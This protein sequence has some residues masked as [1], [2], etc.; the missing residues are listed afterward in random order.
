MPL[1]TV[2]LPRGAP[3]FARGPVSI[4]PA[5]TFILG[6]AATPIWS[7]EPLPPLLAPHFHAP[8]EFSGDFGTY[9]S[10]LLF[11]DGS[12]VKSAAD[13]T[14]R[15]VEIRNKWLAMLGGDFELL[16]SPQMKFFESER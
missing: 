12:Q 9:R 6:S 7:E 15:R 13:W 8:A 10:P 1:V 14:R 5:F 3:M 2:A 11:E 4:L 16:P